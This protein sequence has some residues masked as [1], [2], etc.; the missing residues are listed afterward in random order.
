MARALQNRAAMTWEGAMRIL[1][2]GLGTVVLAVAVGCGGSSSSPA[3]TPASPTPTPTGTPRSLHVVGAP[4][5]YIVVGDTAEFKAQATMSDNTVADVTNL[6]AWTTSDPTIFAVAA[7]GMVTALKVGSADI[8]ATWQG[9]TDKDY[10]TAQPYLTFTLYGTVTEAPPDFAAV[11][12]ASVSVVPVG[13]AAVTT[14]GAGNFSFV[15][16]KGGPYTITIRRDGFIAQS[17]TVTLTR[18]TRADFALL[19]VP[20]SGATARCKD[21]TWSFTTDRSAVCARNG[22]VAYFVCPGP[23]CSS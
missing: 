12:G 7:G 23:L 9:F 10:T 1:G 21:R 14:D 20:P 22:G 5:S 13:A 15:P 16:M 17:R 6:A 19:P 4:N 11:P 3:S 2:S 8:R 18:D